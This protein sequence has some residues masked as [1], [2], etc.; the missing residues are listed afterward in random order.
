MPAP[1]IRYDAAALDLSPR[2]FHTTTVAASPTAGTIT[3]IASLT[4]P[5]DVALVKA[6]YLFGQASWTV[7]TNG[8]TGL[9]QIRQTDTSGT[10][11]GTTGAATVVATNLVNQA[12]IGVD[13]AAVLPGQV[14]VLALTVG[15]GSAGSTVGFVRLAALVV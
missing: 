10:V 13:T 15:S 6:V 5:P 1:P 7:G 4:I 14:Y 3:A 8:V 12:V 9:L 2:V 11:V